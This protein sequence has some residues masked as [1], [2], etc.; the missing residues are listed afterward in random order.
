MEPTREKR[1]KRRIAELEIA[2]GPARQTNRQ[3]FTHDQIVQTLEL[4]AGACDCG[5]RRR[6]KKLDQ[7]C[8]HQFVELREDPLIV[9]EYRLHGYICPDNKIGLFI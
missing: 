7:V 6:G 3:P 1:Y 8:I 5:C 9:T 2:I 4:P